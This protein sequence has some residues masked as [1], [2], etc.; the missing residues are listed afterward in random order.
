M[1]QQIY[2]LTDVRRDLYTAREPYTQRGF[3]YELEV[4]ISANGVIC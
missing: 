4:C 1:G 2:R 3:S